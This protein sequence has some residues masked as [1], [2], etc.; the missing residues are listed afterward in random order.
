VHFTFLHLVAR[1]CEVLSTLMQLAIGP[2][3]RSDLRKINNRVIVSE[4]SGVRVTGY[5]VK[6]FWDV[7]PCSHVEV[8]P[9]FIGSYCLHHQSD[10]TKFL[11]M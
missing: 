6:V 1:A 8:H 11:H 7:A 2:Y 3:D 9:R 4:I 5:E 10:D